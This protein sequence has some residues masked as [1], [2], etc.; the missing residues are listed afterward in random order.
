MLKLI[1]RDKQFL[2]DVTTEMFH[3]DEGQRVT[4]NDDAHWL[5][6]VLSDVADLS[7]RRVQKAGAD[8]KRLQNWV[9]QRHDVARSCKPA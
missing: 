3:I 2:N 8:V 5:A 9:P 1:K 4:S 7:R 6:Q